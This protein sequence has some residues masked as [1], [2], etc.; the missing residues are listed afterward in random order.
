MVFWSLCL[1]GAILAQKLN[2]FICEKKN[3]NFL[4]S[5]GPLGADPYRF[6]QKQYPNWLCDIRWRTSVYL[7]LFHW[8]MGKYSGNRNGVC[9]YVRVGIIISPAQNFGLPNLIWRPTTVLTHQRIPTGSDCYYLKLSCRIEFLLGNNK[10]AFLLIRDL[11]VLCKIFQI[12]QLQ[13]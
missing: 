13:F 9:R 11:R 2:S 1:F 5:L 7:N 8:P 6:E 12:T 3:S 4:T 10:R